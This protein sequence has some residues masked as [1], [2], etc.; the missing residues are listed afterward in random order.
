[1]DDV[2]GE[3]LP[4]LVSF[5]ASACRNT[6]NVEFFTISMTNSSDLIGRASGGRKLIAIVHADMVGYSRLIGL[7][8][9]GTLT[10]LQTLR[11]TL[12][13]PAI[14]EHGG[15]VVQT[16]GDSLLI[17]FDSIEGA[18]RCAIAIQQQV[19]EH[20]RDQ[21]A[22]RAIR[23]RIGINIGDVIADGMDLH[24]DGVNVAAR[25]QAEC[26]TGGVCVSRAVHDHVHARLDLAFEELGP[27]NLK[28]I[29]R[30]VEAFV[31]RL[32]ATETKS[33]SGKPSLLHNGPE[34]I[35]LPDKPSIAVLAF[36]NMSG[37]P[38]QEYFSDGVA[39]DIITELSRS[40][41]LFVIAR[42][43]SFTYKGRTIDVKQVAR[44]LGV[45]YVLG[46]SLRRSGGRVRISAQLIDAEAGHHLW[47]E[48]YD[49]DDTELF[50][51]Q[52]EITAA[53]ATA[54]HPAIADAE[55][56]RVLRKPPESLGA[57]EVYQRGLWH[58]AKYN[59][60]D[61]ERAIEFFRRA[62][63]QDETFVAAYCRLAS[64][65]CESGVAYATRPLDE[66][67]SLAGIWARKAAEI[68][69]QDAEVQSTLGLVAHTSGRR[70]EAWECALLALAISPHL[71]RA[72][73]LKGGILI[74]NG[75]AAEGRNALLTALR[76]N[77]RDPGRI[78][79]RLNTIA[80][81]YYYEG[82][83]AAAAEAARRAMARYPIARYPN[84]LM[85]YRWL[86]AALGQLGQTDEAHEALHT[87]MTTDP[88]DF[89]RFVR[90]RVPWHRPEDYEHML[91]GLRKAG[92]Q[93]G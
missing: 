88:K 39:D 11:R 36:T 5:T 38:N 6:V 82:D 30:P 41:S 69:P 55:V 93:E 81:S 28:N 72:V 77:P 83:Y 60:A 17:V 40:R 48:R 74:F 21:P 42:N 79:S 22:D 71:D 3:C 84:N 16:A 47:A 50:A 29:D 37:D 45:R 52:D 2:I 23:F 86:A 54:I 10:R 70:E 64:A 46:G 43:S 73:S 44:E 18:V 90:N 92:W 9:I 58:L 51:V 49:R 75:Q 78:V 63:A 4:R 61:N 65:Y 56:R 32:D 67:L 26:P 76:L 7:D 62:I 89:D 68:D 27:L 34:A 80:I 25:L 20:D 15:R 85:P 1:V 31:L 66:A 57:W 91:D 13:D 24:G 87:A 19:P 33:K 14:A 12:I 8:D 53:V 59:A 35:P